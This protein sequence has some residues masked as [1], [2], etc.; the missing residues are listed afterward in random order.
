LVREVSRVGIL[1]GVI[2]RKGEVEVKLLQ[3]A[4]DTVFFCQPK[5]KC[6]VAIKA[7]LR[8]FEIVS[9]LKVNFH[10]SQV[11]AIGI[12]DMDLNIFSNCLN[13]GRMELSFKYLEIRIGGNPRKIEF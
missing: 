11:E 5:Y 3:F 10:K 1:E 2:I 4:D 7:I 8:N 13:C 6:M 12:L 9:G